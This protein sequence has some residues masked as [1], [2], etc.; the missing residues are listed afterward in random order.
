VT[1]SR[2]RTITVHLERPDAEFLHKL[3]M[4]W[5]AV[6]P[7]GSPGRGTLGATPP[8][9]GP[10]RVARWDGRRGGLL[11]RNPYFGVA[12]RWR[13]AG[14]ADRI[15]VRVRREGS[16]EA[17]IAA[18]QRGSADLAVIANPFASAVSHDRLR[19]LA[20]DSPG[21][22]QSTP[23][24]TTDWLFLDVRRRPFD[25]IRVRRAV[26]LAID[27]A[28]I[29]TLSGGPEVGQPACQVLPVAF[30]AHEPYCPYTA[31]PSRAGAWTA[32]DLE[33]ARSLV[34]ASGRAG[35]R[36]IVWMPPFRR[37][38]GRYVTALLN[39]L[40][41]RATLRIP[42]GTGFGEDTDDYL[43][44]HAVPQGW[45]ADY[46]APST[47]IETNFTCAA[48]ADRGGLN[49]SRLCDSTLE[50]RI[51]RAL[52][53]PPADAAA[54][55]AAA[56]QRLTDLAAAVP[57]TQRRAVVLV[58]RRVGNVQTHAQWFTLLDELWVK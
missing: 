41:F 51:D 20:T 2:A 10:Y 18:V 57:M 44:A 46:L 53:L 36:I 11:V 34:A 14:F 47:F 40:G 13:P 52:A 39:R 48:T 43:R 3:T 23:V 33:R 15:E 55:W 17:Q 21:R 29:V 56:E 58:S 50:R 37:A 4:M 32:P 26:N 38:V 49:L 5:A 31:H 9:T 42:P 45:A 30:P 22:V 12:S 16:V 1:D 8:G 6:V 27:R 25:D 35:A 19:A 7:A 54:A 28:R 24:P